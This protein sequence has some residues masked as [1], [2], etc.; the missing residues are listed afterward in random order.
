MDH[1]VPFHASAKVTPMAALFV[2]EPTAV[3]SPAELQATPARPLPCAPAGSGVVSTDHELPFHASARVFWTS[4]LVC[5]DADCGAGARRVCRPHRQG[6]LPPHSE[7]FGVVSMDH[8]L[9]F[10]TSARVSSLGLPM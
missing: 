1:E 5:V 7:G 3:Q 6:R 2:K 9:P 8:E 10:Q 4:E